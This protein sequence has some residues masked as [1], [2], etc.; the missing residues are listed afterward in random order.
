M[1]VCAKAWP[2]KEAVSTVVTAIDLSIGRPPFGEHIRTK[3]YAPEALRDSAIGRSGDGGVG[4]FTQAPDALRVLAQ[5]F[6]ALRE[7][8]GAC[9]IMLGLL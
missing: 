7:L 8:Y 2:T 9:S 5:F 6:S 3:I 1:L 4:D